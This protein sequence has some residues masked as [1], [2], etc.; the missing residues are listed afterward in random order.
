MIG[1]FFDAGDG[2]LSQVRLHALL[3]ILFGG[4]WCQTI[5]HQKGPF[6]KCVN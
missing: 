6:E 3:E 5:K 2:L 4:L 1:R